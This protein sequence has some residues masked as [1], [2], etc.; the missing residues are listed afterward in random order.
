MQES[1]KS[2]DRS[3]RAKSSKKLL[4]S[5]TSSLTPKKSLSTAETTLTPVREKIPV[6]IGR[7]AK[8]PKLNFDEEIDQFKDDSLSKE[9]K[10]DDL[11]KNDQLRHCQD[12]TYNNTED[13][14]H[15][16]SEE[17]YVIPD[18]QVSGRFVRRR[19]LLLMR[20]TD[21]VHSPNMLNKTFT[22]SSV[23]SEFDDTTQEKTK[24]QSKIIDSK[25]ETVA[26]K[27][28]NAIVVNN[29]ITST[30][31]SKA[32][33]R[34]GLESQDMKVYKEY[35]VLENNTSEDPVSQTPSTNS[36]PRKRKKTKQ[37]DSLDYSFLDDDVNDMYSQIKNRRR[38]TRR[39]SASLDSQYYIDSNLNSEDALLQSISFDA[40]QKQNDI[41]SGETRR[42]R[43][44][45]SE[46]EV[47]QVVNSKKP[48]KKDRSISSLTE[49]NP[50]ET[51]LDSSRFPLV[52]QLKRSVENI[53]HFAL[54]DSQFAQLKLD[55][56]YSSIDIT[57]LILE[58]KEDTS[59]E[60]NDA[61]NK[62]RKMQK[63]AKKETNIESKPE[64]EVTNKRRKE[65]LV[66]VESNNN[67]RKSR[68]PSNCTPKDENDSVTEATIEMNPENISG[69]RP[70]PG[71]KGRNRGRSRKQAHGL[72]VETA[73]NSGNDV[74]GKVAKLPQNT[75]QV[76]DAPDQSQID[77]CSTGDANTD[78]FT[79][80]RKRTMSQEGEAV[81]EKKKRG[82]QG[83]SRG[84]GKSRK[85]GVVG[86]IKED[87]SDDKASKELASSKVLKNDGT[88]G[89]EISVMLGL[90]GEF[91]VEFPPG[92]LSKP[93]VETLPNDWYEGAEDGNADDTKTTNSANMNRNNV[94]CKSNDK[95]Q[96]NPW[97]KSGR[98]CVDSVPRHH[99]NDSED[100]QQKDASHKCQRTD[101]SD[102]FASECK[103]H[104]DDSSLRN[105]LDTDNS[106]CCKEN[107]NE[108]DQEI[109]D[110][111]I[112]GSKTEDIVLPIRANEVKAA[113]K[114]SQRTK[115]KK[116]GCNISM[117]VK[118]C[119]SKVLSSSTKKTSQMEFYESTERQKI[120]IRENTT[121]L[122]MGSDEKEYQDEQ[123]GD[124]VVECKEE[125]LGDGNE[126]IAGATTDDNNKEA[127]QPTTEQMG[128]IG[129]AF[130]VEM[131][132]DS[133]TEVTKKLSTDMEEV[134]PL[135][136][137]NWGKTYTPEAVNEQSD[138][139]QQTGEID[140][141]DATQ[142][143]NSVS[144]IE[145]K[146]QD[147][148]RDSVQFEV[149]GESS[150][151]KLPEI[152]DGNIVRPRTSFYQVKAENPRSDDEFSFPESENDDTLLPLSEIEEPVTTEGFSC[153]TES[154]ETE[155]ALQ[156]TPE[157]QEFLQHQTEDEEEFAL[158]EDTEMTSP[159]RS[160]HRLVLRE[161]C[162]EE[163][164]R[165]LMHEYEKR[166]EPKEKFGMMM[167]EGGNDQPEDSEHLDTDNDTVSS[168]TD[169]G[170]KQNGEIIIKHSATDETDE[171]DRERKA[172]IVDAGDELDEITEKKTKLIGS[173]KMISM[174]VSSEF[175][176]GTATDVPRAQ[177]VNLRPSVACAVTGSN[178][179]DSDTV[180]KETA[181]ATESEIAG[182]QNPIEKDRFKKVSCETEVKEN[183]NLGNSSS[184]EESKGKCSLVIVNIEG[185]WQNFDE[186]EKNH[187]TSPRESEDQMLV[188]NED[189]SKD[190]VE[191]VGATHVEELVP[192]AVEQRG[193]PDDESD[194]E[195]VIPNNYDQVNSTGD[196][197]IQSRDED[198]TP[199]PEDRPT[200]EEYEMAQADSE[201]SDENLM[202]DDDDYDDLNQDIDLN[203]NFENDQD[204]SEI[205]GNGSVSTEGQDG[206][207]DPVNLGSIQ[208]EQRIQVRYHLLLMDAFLLL[209]YNDGN[210]E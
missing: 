112:E 76:R 185:N 178:P 199:Q 17:P 142:A 208:L 117:E 187:K 192:T 207:V 94:R 89:E 107:G 79:K 147:V 190:V 5:N 51:D 155:F 151:S 108:C 25:D 21:T 182:T 38:G 135:T 172:R 16:D 200:L 174:S 150:K 167:Q 81:Q 209:H 95:H 6:D 15:S 162:G 183:V 92:Y 165:K 46:N 98:V 143:G 184:D 61:S 128:I 7:P 156:L 180:T 4:D 39:L 111:S 11:K 106:P 57:D 123:G 9:K 13:R 168:T 115:R 56:S 210:R 177:E 18:S 118:D 8:K 34:K 202:D 59:K 28:D 24:V 85:S 145:G 49:A 80:K 58:S 78:K 41:F 138:K 195:I 37:S 121:F 204:K 127:V 137:K 158:P 93:I 186:S 55:R 140:G 134:D 22:I 14:F 169:P 32:E 99:I 45:R 206:Q 205:N 27:G 53:T 10:G 198:S 193:I 139:F 26:K 153:D 175:I 36:K 83:N 54:P 104:V 201:D 66:Q 119:S 63:K 157:V 47:A 152:D 12:D 176:T 129:T 181:R 65:R 52:P 64:G 144:I 1:S 130:I 42:K 87:G 88:N 2:S 131:P 101:G 67:K 75:G 126:K 82:G 69:S 30:G 197:G 105:V 189:L 173:G 125:R 164:G 132:Q 60:H 141:R 31:D 74:V 86:K 159:V 154:E 23:R 70:V 179:Y 20:T 161:L 113:G 163:K 84:G 102:T 136:V 40:S 33:L 191:D 160:E 170:K 116:K 196:D 203:G 120:L 68:K 194:D 109:Q 166:P 97:N 149:L 114:T 43:R 19:S 35:S 72:V 110:N 148:A 122:L 71:T 44:K 50:S 77:I 73:K 100:S 103:S 96:D 188:A 48:L 3:T 29:D 91:E 146:G 171:D 62:T 133:A 90:D 124:V